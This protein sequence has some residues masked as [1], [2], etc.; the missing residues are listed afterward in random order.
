MTIRY[1]VRW[2]GRGLP[3]PARMAALGL[4]AIALLLPATAR[5]DEGTNPMERVA[6]GSGILAG[7]PDGAGVDVALIDS[8]VVPVGGLAAPGRVGG[9]LA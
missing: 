2:D 8:G 9:P 4:A 6:G 1:G 7:A 3:K 5:A